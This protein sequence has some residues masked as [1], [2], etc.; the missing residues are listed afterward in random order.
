MTW[1]NNDICNGC[2]ECI[3]VC[4]N[5]AIAM[6]NGKFIIEQM[7]CKQCYICVSFCPVGAIKKNKISESNIRRCK[8]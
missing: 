5:N 2:E 4:S 8:R 1:I 3:L 7:K 6:V